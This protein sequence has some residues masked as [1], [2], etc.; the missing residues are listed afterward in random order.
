MRKLTVDEINVRISKKNIYI[1]EY[2]GC[3]NSVVVFCKICG[4]SWHT[5]AGVILNL[6]CGCPKCQKRKAS[7]AMRFSG[8]EFL[9]KHNLEALYEISGYTNAVKKASFIC[10]KCGKVRVTDPNTVARHRKCPYCMSKMH[11]LTDAEFLKRVKAAHGDEYT[12]LGRYEAL[13]KKVKIKHNS[14]GKVFY[15][16]P[17]NFIG[18]KNKAPCGCP[19]CAPKSKG[20]Q[21]ITAALEKNH[22]KFVQQYS[23]PDCRDRNPLPFDFAL[24]EKNGNISAVIEFDGIQHYK[25]GRKSSIYTEAKLKTTQKH[26]TIKTKFCIDHNIPL[27]RIKYSELKDIDNTVKKILLERSTTIESI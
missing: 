3:Q 17:D 6:G 2:N 14:C 15:T 8:E 23:F 21:R 25:Y 4:Y 27:Y 11:K 7:D 9:R 5:K 19:F 12:I 20:E 16:R 22:A 26:D 18:T 24:L 13:N 1:K 10:K